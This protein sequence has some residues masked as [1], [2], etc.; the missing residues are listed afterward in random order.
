MENI[1]TSE[2]PAVPEK[3]V[4]TPADAPAEKRI[5]LTDVNV[6]DQNVALNV[7]VGFLNIAQR[8]GA[9]GMDE[10]AK[11]WEAVKFFIVPAA[12]GAGLPPV[13]EE[14]SEMA[15]PAGDITVEESA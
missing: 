12:D 11:V 15:S 8:R 4:E 7:L 6:T 1:T 5:N 14:G 13:P 2:A 3:P 10:S 9:F